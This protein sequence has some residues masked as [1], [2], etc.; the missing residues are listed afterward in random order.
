MITR[1]PN[2]DLANRIFMTFVAVTQVTGN[3]VPYLLDKKLDREVSLRNKVFAIIVN[4]LTD[5]CQNYDTRLNDL[6]VRA[7]KLDNDRALFYISIV[8]VYIQAAVDLLSVFSR[9]EMIFIIETRHQY[10][11]GHLANMHSATRQ[12]KFVANRKVVTAKISDD[13]YWAAY[14]AVNN[15]SE[16]SETP[17]N[18]L[19][20]K[21]YQHLTLFWQIDND[22]RKDLVKQAIYNDLLVPN[23]AGPAVQL[24]FHEM[25]Y[26][27]TI[28][29]NPNRLR[30][31]HF[32][33]DLMNY[34][35]P[36]GKDPVSHMTLLRRITKRFVNTACISFERANPDFKPPKYIINFL[37][38]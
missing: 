29:G 14:R 34:G 13:D 26:W 7:R 9:D 27:A 12:I 11:H 1:T 36:W 20:A 25:G 3:W 28:Q 22:L 2:H 38:S 6:R 33:R 19:R 4:G 30:N 24:V 18:T 8:E 16:I 17:L 31:L 23:P 37:R 32:T 15:G 35:P 10:V 21:L 5:A